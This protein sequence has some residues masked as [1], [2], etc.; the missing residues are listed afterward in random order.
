ME[1]S[2][3]KNKKTAIVLSGGVIKAGAWHL[4][5]ALALEELGFSF[6]SNKSMENPGC[7]IG[8]YVGSSA[9]SFINAYLASGIRPHQVVD[10]FLN[11]R[12]RTGPK[13]ITYKNLFSIRRP[14]IGGVWSGFDFL[15]DIPLF[16]K[17]FLKPM[18]TING[19]FSTEGLVKYLKQSVLSSNSYE[20]YNADLFTVASHLDHSRKI[21]F[22]KYKYPNPRH[23]STSVYVTGFP[24]AETV[25]ASMSVPFIYTPYPL[26]DP[27][28]GKYDYFIDGEIRETLSTH[29]AVDNRCELIISSWTHTPYHYQDEIGS[30]VNYGLPI[31]CVQ[32]IHLMI[33]KKIIDSRSRKKTAKDV[34]S[35]VNLLMKEFNVSRQQRKKILSILERKLDY[36]PKVKFIDIYPRH[37]DYRI[38]FRNYFSL[39]PEKSKQIVTAG[40]NRTMEVF[41]DFLEK[42]G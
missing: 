39:N 15:G 22:G 17:T 20:D 36:N 27:I 34:L 2:G 9:G 42:E 12:S 24:I 40:Y 28:T 38:F 10:S 6:K 21:V 33:E 16:L 13:P 25:G 31:I 23:D 30:L 4:G 14:S 19:L 7:E 37:E 41:R 18:F 32:A 26:K 1:I 8:T 5:V 11:K 29:V 35:T 3:L